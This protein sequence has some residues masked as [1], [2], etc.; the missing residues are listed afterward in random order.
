MVD[1]ATV[2]GRP[3]ISSFSEI[4]RV[5]PVVAT[6]L[7][8]G[9]AFA[10]LRA[11]LQTWIAF[12]AG[13]LSLA[14]G[15]FHLS[16]VERA[17]A[18]S[19]DDLTGFASG[20]GGIAMLLAAAAIAAR[21]K[22]TR[23]RARRCTVR[24]LVP[25]A[26]AAT[27]VLVVVPVSAAIYYAHKPAT[28]VESLDLPLAHEDVTLHTS[29]G[30]DLAAWYVPSR[31]GAAVVLS[32]GA[33]GDRNG[34]IK[35]RALMLARHGYGVLV[36]DAR[37][38]G[39]SEGRPEHNGWTW[40]RDVRAAVDYLEWRGIDR[41]GA[42]GLSTGGEVVLDATAH[43]ERIDAVVS[44]G[45]SARTL[46]EA[47]HAPLTVETPIVLDLFAVRNAAYR[48]L[49]HARAP[50]SLF[51]LVPRIAPRSVFLI[52]AGPAFECAMNERY[53]YASELWKL[54]DTAHT[55]GLAEHP[56]EYERRVIA[57]LDGAL[58]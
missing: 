12:V 11:P 18:A 8:L 31:N 35:S 42:L 3:G 28:A 57:F 48:V 52:C 54:P 46:G 34:G 9:L 44:E 36:W 15:A 45:A 6:A 13:S 29:D 38:S 33:G 16:H 51:D 49:T 26:A 17:G 53:G 39:A 10:R 23:S 14:D 43:D 37:G 5:A 25:V 4:L 7:M 56:R 19:G 58:L 1:D 27:L 55:G 21:P 47:L 22:P 20:L 41:I 32:H 2:H 40:G 24:A 50:E 30:L